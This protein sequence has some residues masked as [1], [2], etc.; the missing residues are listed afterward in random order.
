MTLKSFLAL[1]ALASLLIF[2]ASAND[3]PSIYFVLNGLSNAVENGYSLKNKTIRDLQTGNYN[4]EASGG[5]HNLLKLPLVYAGSDFSAG[6]VT[7]L[8]PSVQQ[9]L[10]E[11][12]ASRKCSDCAT[13]TMG[14]YSLILEKETMI[15]FMYSAPYDFDLYTNYL[16]VAACPIRNA[17]CR[18]LTSSNMY[19]N[20]YPFMQRKSFYDPEV[21][22]PVGVC[23]G[24]RCVVGWMKADHH[25]LVYVLVL[26]KTYDQLD[27]KIKKSDAMSKVTAIQYNWVM[28][29]LTS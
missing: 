23:I 6:V 18:G 2:N 29:K 1:A 19:Y 14:R 25:P 8:L 15:H 22:D 11:G 17:Q 13:G 28:N 27:E 20:D 9:G 7:Y 26:P 3:H 16:A 24:E 21:L 5:V 12:F 4:V 10:V